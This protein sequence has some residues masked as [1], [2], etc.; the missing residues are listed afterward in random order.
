MTKH[1]QYAPFDDDTCLSRNTVG[2]RMLAAWRC[3]IP[4]IAI[5]TY[6]KSPELKKCRIKIAYGISDDKCHGTIVSPLF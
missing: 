1:N 6:A 3:T 4:K 5:Y 2:L